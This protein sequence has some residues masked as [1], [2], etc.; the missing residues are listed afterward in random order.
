MPDENSCAN[1]GATIPADSLFCER[2]GQPVGGAPQEPASREP[3]TMPHESPRAVP[4]PSRPKRRIDTRLL[5]AAIGTAVAVILLFATVIG[6]GLMSITGPPAT[7]N[8]PSVTPGPSAVPSPSLPANAAIMRGTVGQA[9][10]QSGLTI[11]LADYGSK[12]PYTEV[13]N[14]TP[15]YTYYRVH[16]TLAGTTYCNPS[17]RITFVWVWSDGHFTQ[18]PLAH[19][20]SNQ[21]GS[22]NT[23]GT[24]SIDPGQTAW[25]F[26]EPATSTVYPVEFQLRVPTADGGMLAYIWSL[27]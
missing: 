14:G 19:C 3:V 5:L 10:S 13:E 24:Y 9:L 23:A 16:T 25:T 15:N 6:P 2:C 20:P 7:N 27:A 18:S 8:N 1:C 17:N 12:I 22:N 11:T 26:W 4:P 21:P